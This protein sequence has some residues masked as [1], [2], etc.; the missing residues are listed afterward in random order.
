MG[1]LNGSVVGTLMSNLGLEQAIQTLGLGFERVNVGDRY[2]MEKLRACDWTLGGETSGH[3]ICLDLTTTGDG[4]ISALQ[5]LEAMAC[6]NQSLNDLKRGM[7]KFPQCL[8]NVRMA[9][10]MD[11]MD[12]PEVR[13]GVR[14]GSPPRWQSLPGK[15]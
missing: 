15:T 12:I 13:D 4:I 11:V 1:E 5:V 6:S 10:K 14:N 7:N 3:I 9:S 2:I 8:V